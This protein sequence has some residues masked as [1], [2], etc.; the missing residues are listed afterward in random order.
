MR[1][2]VWPPLPAWTLAAFFAGAAPVAGATFTVQTLLDAADAA[3]GD[4]ICSSPLAG[5]PCTLRAAVQEAN[6]LAGAD[7]I[8]L[9]AGTTLLSVAGAGEN[10]TATGDLD[11]L[12]DVEIEGAGET[13][14]IVDGALLDRIFDL[15]PTAAPLRLSLRRLT[16]R[17]GLAAG[18]AEPGGCLRNP[19]SGEVELY[20]VTFTDCRS[21]GGGAIVNGGA[22][23]GVEVTFA[24]NMGPLG[25]EDQVQG[26]AILND[27]PG[28]SLDFRRAAFIGN[29]GG[30][31]G[32]LHS[33]GSFETPPRATVRIEDS[34]F[35]GNQALQ[36]GGAVIGNSS[37]DFTFVNCTFSGN[38]AGLGGAIGN[39]GGCFFA[40]HQCT[41]T[42]NSAGIGGGIGEVHFDPS[43]IE[44]RNT[45]LAGNTA[46]NTGP[47]CHF[48][49]HSDG[50]SLIGDLSGCDATLTATDLT[51]IDAQLGTLAAPHPLDR[52]VA[53]PL[54]ADSPAL[55]SGDPL[56]CAVRDQRGLARPQDGDGNGTATCDRGAI[57]MAPALLFHDNADD[58]TL[59][60]WSLSAP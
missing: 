35:T 7:R 37:T 52:F 26:G 4:G 36:I 42:G 34:S 17:G 3:V 51:G 60:R 46:T 6:A 14:T 16:L 33:I 41:I 44:L 8:E 47:D 24:A 30:N 55:D 5:T 48:R 56:W 18:L 1:L 10:L 40:L 9:P 49:L 29:R 11:L 32:A 59:A 23:R 2:A 13:S 50:G 53:H 38:S 15:R 25:N 43:F 20:R 58:G 28:S 27:G 39:D 57:E 45:I 12:D 54:L 22:V 19:A 31:G 21:N